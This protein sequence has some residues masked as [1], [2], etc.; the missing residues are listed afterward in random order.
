[1]VPRPAVALRRSNNQLGCIACATTGRG[2]MTSAPSR[3][4]AAKDSPGLPT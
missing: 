2:F 1:V 3:Q 4:E